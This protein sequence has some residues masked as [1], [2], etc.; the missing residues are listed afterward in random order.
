MAAGLS[1]LPAFIWLSFGDVADRFD[2][3]M[4]ALRSLGQIFGLVGM[5]AMSLSILISARLRV[6][7]R[8]FGG[9]D[10]AVVVHRWLGGAGFLLVLFH[11]L[12]LA[13]QYA[14][15]S[16]RLAWRF[17][18]PWTSSADILSGFLALVILL[19]IVP[20][21]HVPRLKYHLWE[22]SHRLL[23]FSLVLGFFHMLEL[24]SD[25]G[26]SFL[27]KWYMVVLSGTAVL[28]WVWQSMVK[29][30]YRGRRRYGVSAVKRLSAEV[31]EVS[32][33]PVGGERSLSYEPGQFVFVTFDDAH[34]GRE[35]HPY[36]MVSAPS[37]GLIRLAI[38]NL[39]DWSQRVSALKE[40]VTA[41]IEGPF[42]DFVPSAYSDRPQ[43]WIGGGI[44]IT[45]FVAAALA[46]TAGQYVGPVHLFYCVPGEKDAIFM[47]ELRA[48]AERVPELH[49][50]LVCDSSHGRISAKLVEATVGELDANVYWLCGP[51]GMVQSL[52]GQFRKAGVPGGD[53]HFERF[54][55]K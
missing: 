42:G 13:G 27:L 18:W 45:P 30:V 6:V 47:N 43:V 22:I 25:I 4:P 53:V 23:G 11:P 10:K 48:V 41:W 12:L 50:H 38:K 36:T 49:L 55:F 37:E 3:G 54:T 9:F 8:L 28:V 39:G 2:Y 35:R 15:V 46:M 14:Y 24:G 31:T 40:G 51:E 29:L 17:L 32:I 44:G 7:D 16:T 34:V 52:N 5:A 26:S 20:L 33:A 19:A 21:V 1:L